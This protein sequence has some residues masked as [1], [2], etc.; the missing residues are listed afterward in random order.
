[1]PLRNLTRV[2]LHLILIMSMG[3]AG[4]VAPTAAAQ[5]AIAS[6]PGAAA[7]MDMP[8]ADMQPAQQAPGRDPAPKGHCSLA[9]CLGAAACIPE[10][11]RVSA[12]VP[13]S[14]DFDAADVP[15]VPSG[16]LDTPL[17]PPIA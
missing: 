9:A 16:I 11:P 13:V 8:C 5:E 3:L 12:Q 14:A 15:F 17:R 10:M 4:F 7:P 1:M 2:A 6:M